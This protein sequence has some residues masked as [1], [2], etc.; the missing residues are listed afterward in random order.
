ME[1]QEGGGV[2]EGG[3]GGRP[4]EEGREWID[5]EENNKQNLCPKSK[6]NRKNL[7]SG[8][9]KL[10]TENARLE[11]LSILSPSHEANFRPHTYI[12]LGF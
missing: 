6:Y 7:A 8:T 9:Q 12:S 5:E 4:K 1:Q 3:G 11:F 2:G 10:N